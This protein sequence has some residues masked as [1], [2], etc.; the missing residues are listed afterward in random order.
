MKLHVALALLAS[1]SPAVSAFAADSSPD[2][3]WRKAADNRIFAQQLVNG[4][5]AEHPDLLVVGIHAAVPGAKGETMIATNLDRVGKADDD[6]DIAV[7]NEHKT[8]LAPNQTDPHKFEVQVPMKD[9]AGRYFGASMG[10]VFRYNAGDDELKL[11]AE[12]LSIR[13][14][15]ARK[16]PGL[17]A[18][19]APVGPEGGGALAPAAEIRIPGSAGK[20]DFLAVDGPRRRLLA[21]HEKD[22]TADFIDIGTRTVLARVK[23][24]PAVGIAADT[25]NGNYYVSVQDD[26]R[27][28]IIDAATLAETGSV[29]MPA[30]T[31]AILFDA[32]DNRVYVTNDNGRYLWAIDPDAAR[33]AAAIEIPGEPEC[34]AHDAAADRI[35]LN[36]KSLDEVAVIDTR[37]NTVVAAWPTAP[38]TAPH[39]LV[40]DP[41]TGR[42]FTS[43]D[44][45]RLVAIDTKT[46]KVAGSAEIAA[47]VDQIAFDPGTGRIFCA[48]PGALSVVQAAAD[49]L[50][51]LGDAASAA[52][53]KNVAVDPA[54]HDVWTTYTDGKDSFAK[55]WRQ[56]QPAM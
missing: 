38:A 1:L 45:G 22:G 42:I 25:L 44:N 24:G 20:F 32:K 3:S 56:T 17:E 36:I 8:I 31:D 53:A 11:H 43:G 40:F 4:L 54:T 50:H 18:L 48:G 14:E 41:A 21:A 55:S 2:P 7:T 46:G 28:A 5:M 27:V 33:V 35:Y 52:T 19:L 30:E 23:V 34:M 13:D 10:L 16:T 47:H 9:R 37:S 26:K 12:A 51:S 39:G 15:I 49:G 29:A 6:D